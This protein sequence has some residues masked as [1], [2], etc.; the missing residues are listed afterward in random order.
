MII[1]DKAEK[2][3][4]PSM[5]VLYDIDQDGKCVPSYKEAEFNEE[6]ALY[7]EQRAREFKRLHTALIDGE[8]SPIGFF[9]EY[10]RMNL[11]DVSSRARVSQSAVK[12]HMTPVGFGSI[13]VEVLQRYARI[14]DVS[15]ADF[16]SFIFVSDDLQVTSTRHHDRLLQQLTI[17]PGTTTND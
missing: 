9:V 8:I 13:K 2:L 7:Y 3:E 1:S 15:L 5:I 14:F 12:K 6:I 17:A 16:F 4:N 11:K 10:Q